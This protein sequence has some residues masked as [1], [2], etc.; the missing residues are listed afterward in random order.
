M[1]TAKKTDYWLHAQNIPGSHVIIR[2]SEPTEETIEE[3]AKL[4]AYFS[5]YRFSSS[6]PVDLVQVK[7]VRK[8]NGAK[9]GFVIYENQTTYFVTPS[10]QDTEQLQ[11]A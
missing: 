1:R 7:H 2:S 8:P 9:P 3:A 6:V 5:K 11:K 10:K 4:A